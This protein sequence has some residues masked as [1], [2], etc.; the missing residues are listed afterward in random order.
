MKKQQMALRLDDVFASTKMFEIY[1][2]E[3]VSVGGRV[4][5]VSMISNFLFMKYV[6][7]FRRRLPYREMTAEEWESVFRLLERY[8]AKLTIGVTAT[9]V[10]RD[11]AQTPFFEKFPQE[12]AILKE[13]VKAGL[14]EI[15][16][17]GLTHCV[18][19]RH[20][21]QWF[22]S[23][24]KFHREFWPWIPEDVQR[25]HIQRAQ[26]LLSHYFEIDVVT[27]V[28][29]GN[30]WTEQTERMAFHH[31]L[32]VLSSLETKCP[33]GEKNHGLV[34]IGDAAVCAFHD[35]ELVLCGIKWF[36][37]LLKQHGDYDIITIKE[38]AAGF[39]APC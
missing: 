12:A 24:R 2:K 37:D 29:P 19:G 22:S 3:T 31:G 1:G 11:G 34:Y 17:H 8:N 9:W 30:V 38:L 32:R 10:E 16:N 23:N 6:P 20:L 21:P 33:T 27:F 14:V 39:D 15:A 5:P 13:G 28:P 35:R 18:E 25:D 7:G 4:I 36:E 26:A